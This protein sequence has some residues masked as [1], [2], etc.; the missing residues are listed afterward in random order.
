[1]LTARDSETDLVVGLGVGADD[2]LT[3][4]FSSR[5]LVARVHALLRRVGARRRPADDGPIRVG[6]VVDRP[7]DAPRDARR[8]TRRTSR[9]PSSTSSHRLAASPARRLRPR[10]G[11]SSEVWGYHDRRRASARSTRTCARSAASSA[12]D[13]IR[14]VHGVGYALDTDGARVRPLDSLSA[15]SSSSSASSSSPRSPSPCRGRGRRRPGSALSPSIAARR[16]G[17]LALG[18]GAVPRARA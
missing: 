6:D 5:E 17:A 1:M 11:C 2:Y 3:K 14:T 16:R 7:G 13:V 4:P 18:A 10:R 12:P 8:A 9:R 15:R